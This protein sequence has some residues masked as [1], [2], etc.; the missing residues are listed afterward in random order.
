MEAKQVRD[1]NKMYLGRLKR[2]LLY[3][4]LPL[5]DLNNFEELESLKEEQKNDIESQ[6]TLPVENML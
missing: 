2:F 4:D 3:N 1:K 5:S 6:L